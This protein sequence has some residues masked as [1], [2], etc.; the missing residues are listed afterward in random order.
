MLRDGLSRVR[1]IISVQEEY[2]NL[3]NHC[4]YI[5]FFICS[6][7]EEKP[8][9]NFVYRGTPTGSNL[10]MSSLH[11]MPSS[12]TNWSFVSRNLLALYHYLMKTIHQNLPSTVANR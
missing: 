3:L 1:S 8:S 2:F 6:R 7:L 9:F 5:I 4:Y 12:N 11:L 10:H